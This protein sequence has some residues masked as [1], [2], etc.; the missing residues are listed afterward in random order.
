MFRAGADHLQLISGGTGRLKVAADVS[1][2]GSTDL[3]ITG[4]NR[5]LSYTSGTGTVRTTTAADLYLATNSTN[6]VQ[7][8]SGGAVKAT[9]D[10]GSNLIQ[11]ARIHDGSLT[12]NGS[13]TSFTVTHNLETA[14]PIAVVIDHT[15]GAYVEAQIVVASDNAITVTFNNAPASGKVYRVP[16]TG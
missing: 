2:I 3:L 8:T 7:V 11:V 13:A 9:R 10:G 1:V 12:G 5:R 6:R 15:S 16:V 14:K 4:A